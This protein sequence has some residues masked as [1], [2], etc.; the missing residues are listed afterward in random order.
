MYSQLSIFVSSSALSGPERLVP[1]TVKSGQ[2]SKSHNAFNK[3]CARGVAVSSPD[4]F[5]DGKDDQKKFL[6]SESSKIYGKI[7]DKSRTQF[8][9]ADCS[10]CVRQL[11]STARTR[12]SVAL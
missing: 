9:T 11:L 8:K 3:L 10:V 5:P 4:S 7:L 12:R 1:I 2:K 6:H